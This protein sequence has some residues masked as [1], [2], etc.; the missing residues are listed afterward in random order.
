MTSSMS[1]L[2]CKSGVAQFPTPI[3]ISS[4]GLFDFKLNNRGVVVRTSPKSL[5]RNMNTFLTLI[6]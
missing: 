1:G 5:F 4:S 6:I 3:E 2:F